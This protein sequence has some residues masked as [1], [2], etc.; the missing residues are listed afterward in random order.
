[1]R[2]FPTPWVTH[3][4]ELLCH[5]VAHATDRTGQDSYI[6]ACP[7]WK[8]YPSMCISSALHL[9]IGWHGTEESSCSNSVKHPKCP[10]PVNIKNHLLQQL[11]FKSSQKIIFSHCNKQAFVLKMLKILSLYTEVQSISSVTSHPACDHTEHDIWQRTSGNHS[12][13]SSTQ[14][15][16]AEFCW[17][18]L[19]KRGSWRLD[20]KADFCLHVI[21]CPK[22]GAQ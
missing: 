18:R 9:F 5:A 13:T 8:I 6:T 20:F 11:A 21:V 10:V 7:G 14:V 4:L 3:G 17:A 2:C 12:A 22:T 16:P 15:P 1:M 19:C